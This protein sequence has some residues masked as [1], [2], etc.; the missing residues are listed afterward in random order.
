MAHFHNGILD[1]REKGYTRATC[2][3]QG[4]FEGEKMEERYIGLPFT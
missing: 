1:C 2:Q 3:Q 4:T